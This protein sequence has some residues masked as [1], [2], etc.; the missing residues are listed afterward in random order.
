MKK[1]LLFVCMLASSIVLCAQT[2]IPALMV[3]PSDSYCIDHGYSFM[4]NIG[5]EKQTAIDYYKFVMEDKDLMAGIKI[6]NNALIERGF[7]VRDLSQTI[8][9]L[10]S[11]EAEKGQ[12]TNKF[13]YKKIL[14]ES[15]TD[16]AVNMSLQV[17]KIGP[18]S[19]YYINID[20]VNISTKAVIA[21]MSERNERTLQP[22]DIAIKSSILAH[23]D[24]F[25]H[26]LTDFFISQ[27]K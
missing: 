21:S 4:M 15:E 14:E 13:L 25:C 5:N 11:E 16:I 3:F 1:I 2:K 22:L 6:L 12:N 20:A 18:R 9:S 19:S 17:Q 27:R 24:E 26:Q 23:F 8:K 10:C 7:V